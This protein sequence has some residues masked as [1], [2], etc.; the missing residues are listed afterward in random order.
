MKLCTI[1]SLEKFGPAVLEEFEYLQEG[2]EGL[3]DNIHPHLGQNI[4]GQGGRETK[5]GEREAQD[6]D[7]NKE[8]V[9]NGKLDSQ[10]SVMGRF[11]DFF[12]GDNQDGL[13]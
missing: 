1:S 8:M 7:K 2:V 3:E 12:W 5:L 13:Y 4:S 11:G 10:I 6:S 9:V